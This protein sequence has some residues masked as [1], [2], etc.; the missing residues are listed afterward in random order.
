MKTLLKGIGLVLALIAG[1]AQ[2]IP[3]LYFNGTISFNFSTNILGVNSDLTATDDISPIPNWSGGK[4]TLSATYLNTTTP[5]PYL[6]VNHFGN[7]NMTVTDGSANTL[8]QGNF[9][10]LL[11]NNIIGQDGGVL[12]GTFN[13][14]SG[15]LASEFKPG[16]LFSLGF[17]MNPSNDQNVVSGNING[18][19]SGQDVSVPEPGILALLVLGVVLIGFAGKQMGRSKQFH[20]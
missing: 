20:A 15:S 1:S 10:E 5:F 3:T 9:S 18:H 8:L 16:N 2:A 17:N 12:K 11:V 13:A 7:G 4:L 6:T 14:I 19:M